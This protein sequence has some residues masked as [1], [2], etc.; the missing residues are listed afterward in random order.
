[1]FLNMP[2]SR[3][4]AELRLEGWLLQTG[5]EEAHRGVLGL[6]TI[7]LQANCGSIASMDGLR[8]RKRFGR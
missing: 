1:M 3:L 8:N 4:A 5:A 6:C 2:E 7:A